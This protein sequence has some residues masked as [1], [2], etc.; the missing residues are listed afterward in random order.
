MA[1]SFDLELLMIPK[2]NYGQRRRYMG[3]YRIEISTPR[4]NF[5]QNVKIKPTS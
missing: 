2:A 3:E 1:K 5:E 4:F